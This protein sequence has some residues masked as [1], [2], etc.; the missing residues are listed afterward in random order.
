MTYSIDSKNIQGVFNLVVEIDG[1]E[2]LIPTPLDKQGVELLLEDMVDFIDDAIWDV[3]SMTIQTS[4]E[5][6]VLGIIVDMFQGDDDSDPIT[7]TFWFEDYMDEDD[8]DDEI[9]P[10]KFNKND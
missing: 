5:I 3:T 10:L 2:E 8:E 7:T 4:D 1:T 9:K 6:P